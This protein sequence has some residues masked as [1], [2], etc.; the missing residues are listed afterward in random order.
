MNGEALTDEF[1]AFNK[2]KHPPPGILRR[3]GVCFDV[4]SRV[5]TESTVEIDQDGAVTISGASGLIT[6]EVA[7]ALAT[8]IVQACEAFEAGE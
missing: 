6:L 5:A 1:V 4:V 8:A 2:T 7:K 3:R